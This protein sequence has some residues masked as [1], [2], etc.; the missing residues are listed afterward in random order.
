MNG[1]LG[2]F[3]IARAIVAVAEE[4]KVT[5]AEKIGTHMYIDEMVGVSVLRGERS[6]K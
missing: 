2:V 3:A 4:A 5:Y 6:L 1:C